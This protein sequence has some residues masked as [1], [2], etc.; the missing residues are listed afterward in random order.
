MVPY[1]RKTISFS[2]TTCWR[3]GP[4]VTQ[5]TASGRRASC[6][7]QRRTGAAWAPCG[8]GGGEGSRGREQGRGDVGRVVGSTAWGL[9]R[10]PEGVAGLRGGVALGV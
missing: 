4:Q 7:W 5:Q 2:V 8:G 1:L 10:L 9:H 6:G 3:I